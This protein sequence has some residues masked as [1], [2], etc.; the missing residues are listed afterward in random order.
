MMRGR[1]PLDVVD[2]T[3]E[4]LVVG[5]T[6][7]LDRVEEDAE[8]AVVSMPEK[9][10]LVGASLFVDPRVA[11]RAVEPDEP[12]SVLEPVVRGVVGVVCCTDVD[13]VDVAGGEGSVRLV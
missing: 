7:G 11:L 6:K 2:V 4:K 9:G 5:C 10:F 12:L 3:G 13:S 8:R 1:D